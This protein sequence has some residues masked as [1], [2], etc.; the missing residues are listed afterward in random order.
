MKKFV[1]ESKVILATEKAY[2]LIY[3]NKGFV[4]F[5]EK[6]KKSKKTISEDKKEDE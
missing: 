2:N 6:E 4:P 1:K 3:K 5:A